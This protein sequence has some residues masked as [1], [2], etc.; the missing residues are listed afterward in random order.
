MNNEDKARIVKAISGAAEYYGKPLSDGVLMLYL[1]G[2]AGYPAADVERAIYAHIQNPDT[3]QFMPKIADITRA[4][5]GTTQSAAA[6]AW[7]K[8]Q[9]AVAQ[10]GIYRSIA[11]DD[12]CIHLAIA[13]IGGWQE[14]GRTPVVELPFLQARFE[15]SYRAYAARRHDLPPH[16]GYLVGIFEADNNLRGY[17]VE[18]PVLVGNPDRARAVLAAGS[19]APRLTITAGQAAA[20]AIDRARLQAIEAA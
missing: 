16:P 4:I 19:N 5:G 20:E 14:I 15:K 17:P 3:G 8:V 11:F 18:P 12:A 6:I 7:G 10:I 9:Q 2:L 13:D 1:Q